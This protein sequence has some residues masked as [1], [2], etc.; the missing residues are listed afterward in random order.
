MILAIIRRSQKQYRR[1]ARLVPLADKR[2]RLEAIHLGHLDVEEND[3]E[4]VGEE[5]LQRLA[6]GFGPDQ[7]LT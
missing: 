5:P 7:V 3:R 4:L 2:G 1:M 6:A